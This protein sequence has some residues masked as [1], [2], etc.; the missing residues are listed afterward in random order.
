[1]EEV[2]LVSAVIILSQVIQALVIKHKPKNPHGL[3]TEQQ[4]GWL[5]Q[6]WK[7]IVLPKS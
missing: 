5:E 1:M 2:G 4:H 6:I 7:R 3:L